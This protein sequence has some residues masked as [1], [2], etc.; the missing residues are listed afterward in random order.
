[1]RRTVETNRPVDFKAASAE[2]VPRLRL[3]DGNSD[4]SSAFYG[5]QHGVSAYSPPHHCCGQSCSVAYHARRAA[6]ETEKASTLNDACGR[7][8][9][10]G[11]AYLHLRAAANLRQDLQQT[12]ALRVD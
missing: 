1:M 10:E 12:V 6:E 2:A 9:H 11:L 4:L 3:V 7:L 5:A 8:A